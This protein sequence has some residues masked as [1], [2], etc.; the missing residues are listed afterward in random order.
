MI[1]WCFINI[2]FI[3]FYQ[4]FTLQAQTR[5]YRFV[6]DWK[7]LQPLFEKAPEYDKADG[8][9]V[10]IELPDADGKWF[11]YSVVASSVLSEELQNQYPD[12][13]T[14]SLEGVD[15]KLAYGRVFISRFGM[16]G[17]IIM[18]NKKI[19]IE[20][21][22]SGKEG[23]HVAYLLTLDESFTCGSHEEAIE[24]K[25]QFTGLRN[26]N[27][28]TLRQ[29]EM[30][31]VCTGEFYQSTNFGNNNMAT[32]NAAVV[33]I[34]NLVNVTWNREMSVLF[35][36]FQTPTIYTN[37]ATDPLDPAGTNLTTQAAAAIHSNYGSGGYD[38]GHA[39][40]AM[41]GGGSGV[42][43]VGVV[44]NN[45]IQN[46]GRVNSR[47]WSG[48]L[49]QNLLAVNIM[50]HEVGHMFNSPHTF[51][52]SDGN[53]NTGQHSLNTAFEIGSGSTIM[54]YAGIC[55]THN[56]QSTQDLYF[57][58]KSLELF[59]NYIN[60]SGGCS[61]NSSTN[62]TP[63]TVDAT[64]CAGPYTIPALTPFELTGSGADANGDGLVYTW[65]EIDEDGNGVRPTHGF[66]GATAGNNN[67]APLFR[68]FPPTSTGFKRT[69]PSQSL[70][71]ANNYTSNFEPLPNASRTLNFRLTARDV[72]SPY[73]AYAYDDIAVSVD[74]TKGP[75]TVTA[76]N[77]TVTINAGSN[78][79][80]TWTVNNTQTLCNSVNILLSLDGGSTYPFT[81]LANTPNDGTQ[82]VLFPVNIPGSTQA[83]VRIESACL[84]CLKFF[85]ISNAN[86]TVSSS[87]NTAFSNLCTTAPVTA[88]EGNSQLN[89]SM[90]VAYG[91][92][93]TTQAMVPSGSAVL[94]SLHAGTTP[95]SGG[96]TSL[97]FGDRAATVRFK[98]STSGNYTFNM[99]G[100]FRHL[101][102]YAGEYI[103]SQ[104][105]TNFLGSTAYNGGQISNPITLPLTG[106][107]VYTAVFFD[108]SGTNGTLTISPPANAYV[109]LHNPP[110]NPNYSY[111]YAAVNSTSNVI[112][113]ISPSASFSGLIAGNYCVY[114]LYYYSGTANPPVFYDPATFVGQTIQQLFNSGICVRASDNCRPVTVTEICTT[115]VTTS[116]NNGPGSLRRNTSCNPEGTM[117]T[118]APGVSQILLTESLTI[119]KNIT[120]QGISPGQRP[121]IVTSSAGI[122]ISPGKTLTLQNVD[123]R[124]TGTQTFQGGGTVSITGLT[125]GKQ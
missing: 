97:N 70:L 42:A 72:R 26:P 35:T 15:H 63:P 114:G 116:A 93:F 118:F 62:N 50:V 18:G 110:T 11:R 68:S 1:K 59:F 40:N 81:L 117:L 108:V 78:F 16:E 48:G 46:N 28:G 43:G 44:C 84:T 113:A 88:Q 20:P 69:F 101:S 80:V 32:A 53:C 77:T 119:T 99:A 55:G 79:T 74:A 10:I 56:I 85:D 89:L 30:A 19:K 67:L 37:P 66:I 58:A 75:L 9:E 91:N 49:N 17:L 5:D 38:L 76:P 100:G 86:F 6:P 52:G 112:A 3:V 23:E 115:T 83:R 13:K 95:G 54:S 111:T 7:S 120:L 22:K 47:G 57:H 21:A 96:C 14:Y 34:I 102:I 60:S 64:I 98:P 71:V 31:I 27:G 39:L 24:I 36:I 61:T 103:S 87:C 90:D 8:R 109:Y 2:I 33:N 122:T 121:E 123:V 82:S 65:E 94:S 104:P 45:T 73:A 92:P 25:G 12:F 29:Y 124:H 4:T 105:C 106:C 51:N 107:A 125:V 41:T